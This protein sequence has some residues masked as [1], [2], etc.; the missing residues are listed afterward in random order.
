MRTLETKKK[1]LFHARARGTKGIFLRD[2]LFKTPLEV[3]FLWSAL[4][5]I[6]KPHSCEGRQTPPSQW[7]PLKGIFLGGSVD[8]G[9][10]W[11]QRYNVDGG[12]GRE[13]MIQPLRKVLV[14]KAKILCWHH[15]RGKEIFLDFSLLFEGCRLK[16]PKYRSQ[17]S[18]NRQR[19]GSKLLTVDVRFQTYQHST[20]D[21]KHCPWRLDH[22]TACGKFSINPLGWEVHFFK[23]LLNRNTSTPNTKSSPKRLTQTGYVH[24][25][26]ERNEHE[27]NFLWG[28]GAPVGRFAWVGS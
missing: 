24:H 23:S 2:P 22:L 7:S 20:T 1:G 5:T 8:G 3:F 9:L 6:N 21:E 16:P 4:W 10:N 12:A 18:T 11:Q 27:S 17:R 15:W 19:L 25:W 14:N 26:G 28:T 13:L